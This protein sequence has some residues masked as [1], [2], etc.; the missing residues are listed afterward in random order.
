MTAETA[1]TAVPIVAKRRDMECSSR[2][3]TGSVCGS[4]G[5]SD[6]HVDGLSTARR[7]SWESSGVSVSMYRGA[8]DSL[9]AVM[10]T[11]PDTS[12]VRQPQ[13]GAAA[14]TGV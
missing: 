9:T 8:Y 2:A 6:G 1:E 7:P 10:A 13:A 4:G 14:G 3:L 12:V 5:V 11:G